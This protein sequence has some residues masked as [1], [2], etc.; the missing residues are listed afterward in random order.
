MGPVGSRSGRSGLNDYALRTRTPVLR[1]RARSDGGQRRKRRTSYDLTAGR[2]VHPGVRPRGCWFTDLPSHSPA[3]PTPE[4][5]HPKVTRESQRA[6]A[7]DPASDE[8]SEVGLT[9][10]IRRSNSRHRRPLELPGP[11]V[12]TGAWGLSEPDRR[13]PVL[14]CEGGGD[15][16]TFTLLPL[17]RHYVAR[18]LWGRSQRGPTHISGT[19]RM[20]WQQSRSPSPTP[21]SLPT[22]GSVSRRSRTAR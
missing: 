13:N 7:R 6:G 9:S 8:V 19:R 22:P 14:L 21:I 16:V 17:T 12:G 20:R 18:A 2:I 5:G 4:A 3:G 1:A 11:G 10:V 15:P